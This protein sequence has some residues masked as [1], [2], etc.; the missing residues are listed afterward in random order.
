MIT[1][2]C[3]KCGSTDVKAMGGSAQC[4]KC[5]ATGF[6]ADFI[7]TADGVRQKM[8]DLKERAT[9]LYRELAKVAW[10][11]REL[12]DAGGAASCFPGMST[13][14]INVWAAVYEQWP[15]DRLEEA[16]DD[17]APLQ[18]N[19][20]KAILGTDNPQEWFDKAMA[21]ELKTAQI[22]EMSGQKKERRPSLYRGVA[23]VDQWQNGVMRLFLD[24]SA[25]TPETP[26]QAV[27]LVV[28][29]R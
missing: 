28:R 18:A 3:F 8:A 10:Q 26:P 7:L 24:L 15:G 11:A 9:I 1:Y 12:G 6:Q 19:W 29:E 13:Q 25:E 16:L 22:R 20:W 14:E 27:T 5:G 23:Q 21:E 2:E 4:Q 17:L